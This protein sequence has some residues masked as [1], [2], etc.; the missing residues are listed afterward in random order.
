MIQIYR[1]QVFPSEKN[2]YNLDRS[3]TWKVVKDQE[4]ESM[5]EARA[6]VRE[7][8]RIH[9]ELI[10][11]TRYPD[12]PHQDRLHII[13]QFC[14]DDDRYLLYRRFFIGYPP[15]EQMKQLLKDQSIQCL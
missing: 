5:D 6:Y 10:G 1:I 13:D 15:I 11:V 7:K 9:T 3:E 2:S 14:F 8:S 4:C 12:L